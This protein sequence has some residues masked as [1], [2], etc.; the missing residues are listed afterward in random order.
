MIQFFTGLKDVGWL[1]FEVRD[2]DLA[3]SKSLWISCAHE[4]MAHMAHGDP[5]A[6]VL[7]GTTKKK[8]GHSCCQ[9]SQLEF[10]GQNT[11]FLLKHIQQPQFWWWNGAD[12]PEL[13]IDFSHCLVH[14][15]RYVVNDVT[16]QSGFT[17]HYNWNARPTWTPPAV[18][19]WV[20][21]IER[22]II[23]S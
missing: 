1:F 11:H 3:S 2:K 20:V 8:H 7:V 14:S 5:K 15:G 23:T 9:S 13:F 18:S 12:W 10:N 17:T 19:Q 6:E 16:S 4:H 21:S 22:K